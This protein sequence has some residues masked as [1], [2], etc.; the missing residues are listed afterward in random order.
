MRLT[1]CDYGDMD[2]DGDN[3]TVL[4]EWR[5]PGGV[6]CSGRHQLSSFGAAELLNA[7]KPFVVNNASELAGGDGCRVPAH[8][9]GRR[10]LPCPC[11]ATES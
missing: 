5:A 3:L 10:H 4:G 7:G 2:A 8:Q 9:R 1:V 6:A 11:C